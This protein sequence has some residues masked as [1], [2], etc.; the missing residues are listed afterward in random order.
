MKLNGTL[1]F[2]FGALLIAGGAI[3]FIKAGS[4]ISLVMGATL[5]LT[6]CILAIYTLKGVVYCENCALVM[7]LLTDIFFA[8]RLLK[9]KSFF[10][11]GIITIIASIFIIVSCISIRKRLSKTVN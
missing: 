2:L 1:F 8:Y 5:G 9:A 10:P 7:T 6:I 11:A 3:G 4:I